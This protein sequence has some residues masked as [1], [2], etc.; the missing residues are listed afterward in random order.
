[1]KSPA[2]GRLV[3]T[4]ERSY[5]DD[6]DCWVEPVDSYFALPKDV[7]RCEAIRAEFGVSAGSGHIVNGH[8]PVHT[9]EGEQP[10][11]AN[12]RLLVID[13]GFCSADH[14]TTGSAGYTRISSTRGCRPVHTAEGEQPIRANGRLLVIDGGF[15][16]ADH[17]T[18][19]SAGY[20]RISSTRG[21]RL[22]AHQAFESVEAVLTRNADIVS[23]TDRFDVA[24]RRRMVSDTDTGPT[25]SMW[26]S[27]GAW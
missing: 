14:P 20:T 25:A 24:E 10:I 3:K 26:P 6:P 8:T 18:T 16:S 17:P 5:I 12:G 2:S 23:E 19:G 22:K 1:M 13:G 4:F 27:V 11:R 9:A 7:A 21:C 15:C